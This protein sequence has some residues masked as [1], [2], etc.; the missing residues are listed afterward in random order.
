ME[1]GLGVHHARVCQGVGGGTAGGRSR[2]VPAG[3]PD[4]RHTLLEWI[5]HVPRLHLLLRWATA[6]SLL[7]G[8]VS[9]V[10]WLWLWRGGAAHST[11][12]EGVFDTRGRDE[13]AILST[14]TTPLHLHLRLCCWDGLCLA[15]VNLLL[16]Q[17]ELV[18]CLLARQAVL[19]DE[20]LADRILVMAL[21]GLL[22]LLLHFCVVIAV[23]S[24]IHVGGARTR[25]LRHL[26]VAK[27]DTALLHEATVL[28]TARVGLVALL[29]RLSLA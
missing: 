2:H 24:L 9:N 19:L 6:G 13:L 7:A 27:D 26:V 15:I 23:R 21:D 17:L 11:N 3:R 29:R 16:P 12:F 14:C 25:A 22:V 20:E 18:L 5:G 4:I 28:M 1:V 10:P 8:V